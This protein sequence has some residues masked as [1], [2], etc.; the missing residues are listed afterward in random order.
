MMEIIA[1]IYNKSESNSDLF[2]LNTPKFI[3]RT[4]DLF[5]IT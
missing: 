1:K 4:E 2:F 3:F 5:K